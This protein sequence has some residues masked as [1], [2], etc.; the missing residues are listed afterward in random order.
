MNKRIIKKELSKYM[1]ET[2]LGATNDSMTY[3]VNAKDKV[4]VDTAK[5]ESKTDGV[6]STVE[7]TSED[8]RDKNELNGLDFDERDS[9]AIEYGIQNEKFDKLMKELTESGSPTIKLAESVNPRI[10][11]KDL[12]NHLKNKK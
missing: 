4:A 10:K 7:L 6:D 5:A 2:T 3:A 9:D 11:V 1:S 8:D 12:I